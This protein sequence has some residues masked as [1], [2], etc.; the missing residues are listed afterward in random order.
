VNVNKLKISP[1][2]WIYTIQN[3]LHRQV[4]STDVIG[5]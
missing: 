3:E 5:T 4:Q 1:I 2:M